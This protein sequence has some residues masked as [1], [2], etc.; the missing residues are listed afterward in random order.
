MNPL[1][2]LRE[3]GQSPWYDY[4]RRGMITSGQLQTLI[5]QDGLMGMTSNPAI[6]EKAIAGSTDYVD[7]ITQA[8]SEFLGVKEIYERV[9]IQDIQDA[10][11][12]ALGRRGAPAPGAVRP[13]ADPSPGRARQVPCAPPAAAS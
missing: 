7:A 9:A 10:A 4:I 2:Q 8:A 6:F 13:G 3:Y 1:V 11:E 5:N 12:P